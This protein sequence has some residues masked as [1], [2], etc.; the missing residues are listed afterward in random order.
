MNKIQKLIE[1]ARASDD[2]EADTAC[3]QLVSIGLPVIPSVIEE[4]RSSPRHSVDKF[5]RIV[6]Q[7]REPDIVPML[8]NWSL[9]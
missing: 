4:I 1:M 6:F 5:R 3:S 7:I 9:D 2:K 8:I